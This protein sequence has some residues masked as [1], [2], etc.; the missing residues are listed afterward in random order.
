MLSFCIVVIVLGAVISGLGGLLFLIKAFSEGFLWGLAV[1]FIPFASLFFLIKFWSEAK[2]AFLMQLGGT[3]I[4]F[5]GLGIGIASGAKQFSAEMD[6]AGLDLGGLEDVL[7]IESGLDVPEEPAQRPA[8]MIDETPPMDFE[9][10]EDFVG[11]PLAEV[12]RTLGAPRGRLEADG[13]TVYFYPHF[14]IISDDGVT[15]TRQETVSTAELDPL[16]D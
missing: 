15:V 9:D 8:R 5:M 2:N 6:L 12:R 11:R 1:L 16:A 14:E 7:D 3:L 10:M 4:A 13:K